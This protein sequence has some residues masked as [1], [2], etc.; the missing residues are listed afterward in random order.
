LAIGLAAVV[1]LGMVTA[2]A[3]ATAEV[4]VRSILPGGHAIR[5]TVADEIDR[6]RDDLATVPGVDRVMPISEFPAVETVGD[7]SR[8]VGVAG[9][10]ASDF[11]DT[12]SLIFTA[13][14]RGEAFNALRDGGA[15]LLPESVASRD[16]LAVGDTITL[17]QPGSDDLPFRV[18]GIVAYS[19]PTRTTEG[20]ILMSQEDA[21]ESFGVTEASL[22]ALQ[23]QAGIPADTFRDAVARKAAEYAAEPL[24]AAALS[25]D[26]GRSLD[27][28]IGLFDVLAVLAVVIGGLGIVNT[29]AV[30]VL[31]RG[32]EIAILR[33]HGMTVGQ[34]QAMVVTE[35][36]IIGAVGGLAAV[37]IGVLVAWLTINVAAPGDFAGGVAVPW[38]LLAA[39]VLLGIGVAS[40]AGIYPAR[41]AAN[42]PITDSLKHFE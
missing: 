17:A 35:A 39:V 23:P 9:I 4:W 40:V 7:D 31:E 14:E 33:S 26:L 34:V 41:T 10:T 15:V 5:L 28:L 16:G 20:A 27:R 38:G 30:G 42:L 1:A 13:G 24:S 18:A 22:F 25:S 11:Q 2:S 37:G 36:G 6:V 32:R 8:E 12:R 3:R 21:A 29:L 19:L